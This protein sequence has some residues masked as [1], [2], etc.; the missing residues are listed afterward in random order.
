MSRSH[1]NIIERLKKIAALA[2]RGIGGEK[3]N[4]KRILARMMEKY[5]ITL[6]DLGQGRKA[7]KHVFKYKS[8]WEREILF[9]CYYRASGKNEV[10]YGQMGRGMVVFKLDFFQFLELDAL[11]KYF[12]PLLNREMKLFLIAFIHKHDLHGNEVSEGGGG[13]KLSHDEIEQL[14]AMMSSMKEN[15]YVSPRRQLEG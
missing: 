10:R 9:Q 14:A 13:S 3:E 8:K 6:E 12:V 15:R 4:A 2:E 11:Y 7:K 1:E 5:E